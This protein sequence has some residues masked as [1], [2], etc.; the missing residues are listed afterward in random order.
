MTSDNDRLRAVFLKRSKISQREFGERY[1][2]G[3]AGMV[4]QLLLGRRPVSLAAAVKFAE[5]LGCAIDDFSP[6]LA[7]FARKAASFTHEIETDIDSAIHPNRIPVL[8]GEEVASRSRGKEDEPAGWTLTDHRMAEG[9]FALR[10]ED[11]QMEPHFTAG[12]IVIIEPIAPAGGLRGRSPVGCRQSSVY[13]VLSEN[14]SRFRKNGIRSSAEQQSLSGASLDRRQYPDSRRDDRAPVV[15]TEALI[16]KTDEK[17]AGRDLWI[18]S[19]FAYERKK[20]PFT[21]ASFR[22]P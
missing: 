10:I 5:G 22:E 1:G 11:T 15:Q 7:A 12:D 16:G 8:T 20:T 6:E 9:S 21:S 18:S 17:Q 2:I 3:T 4:N 13:A 14:G 19:R